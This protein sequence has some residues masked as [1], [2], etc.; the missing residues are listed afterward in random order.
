MTW[1]REPARGQPEVNAE[2]GAADDGTGP[3]APPEHRS[4]PTATDILPYVV[5]IFAYVALGGLESYLPQSGGQV[6]PRWYPPAYTARLVIVVLLAWSYRRTW[7]DLRPVPGPGGFVL[8]IL[9]GLLVTTL[10]VGL[11]GLYPALPLLSSHRVG[12]DPTRLAPGPRW[13]FLLARMLGLVALVPL[14]EEL[15]WRSFLIRW[16]I[17]QD[18]QRVPIG[19]V[20]PLAAAMTSVLFALAHPEW[21]PALLTGLLWAWLLRQTQS[22]SACLISHVIANLALGIYVIISGDWKYW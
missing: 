7:K 6:S 15:F 14:I 17:D 4:A 22:L 19:R 2:G 12:F 18:F 13:G 8:A 10:W 5:P 11:D 9:T 21:L 16:V 1:Y 3:Q 20:T